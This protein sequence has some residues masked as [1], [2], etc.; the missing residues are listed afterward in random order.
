MTDTIQPFPALDP[1]HPAVDGDEETGP[2]IS[3][4]R[5]GR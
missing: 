1:R 3:P 4:L 5:A 2:A